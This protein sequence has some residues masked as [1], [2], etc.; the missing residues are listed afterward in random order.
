LEFDIGGNLLR[1]WG[2]EASAPAGVWPRA[3]HT[4]F[5]DREHNV[6]LAGAASGDTLLKF[7]PR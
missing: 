3:V 6:W 5:V 4:I 1:S 2:T 7:T